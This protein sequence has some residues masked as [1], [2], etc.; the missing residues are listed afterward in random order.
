MQAQSHM[1]DELLVL[2]WEANL[3]ERRRLFSYARKHCSDISR[4]FMSADEATWRRH[5]P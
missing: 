2:W 4:A 5:A 3:T 1:V